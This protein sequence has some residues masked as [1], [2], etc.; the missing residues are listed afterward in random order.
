MKIAYCVPQIITSGGIERVLSNKIKYLLDQGYEVYMILREKSD[1]QPFFDF[2]NRIIYYRM[3]F[4]F[5][6]RVIN[7]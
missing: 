6:S 7:E 5:T 3:E 4:D 1:E 2:D